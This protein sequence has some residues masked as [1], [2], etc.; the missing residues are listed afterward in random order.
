MKVFKY[1]CA[2]LALSYLVAALFPSYLIV[3]P[4]TG[5][6]HRLAGHAVLIV[7]SLLLIAMLYGI[8]TRKPI[9]WKLIPV[10]VVIFLLSVFVPPLW[11]FIQNRQPWVPFAFVIIFFFIGASSFM[12]WW[13]KQKNYFS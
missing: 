3:A 11:T 7:N 9:F 5:V 12:P 10:L 1:G 6:A 4:H 8:Q 13:R 2:I